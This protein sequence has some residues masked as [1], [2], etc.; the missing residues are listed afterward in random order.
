[1][2][3]KRPFNRR[4]FLHTT[5]KAGILLATP[6]PSVL[7]ASDFREHKEKASISVFSKHIQWLEYGPMAE[8]AADIGFTGIDLTV[9]PKGHVLPE[10]VKRDLPKA[11]KAIQKNGLEAVMMTTAISDPDDPA[12]E[13]ILKTAADLGIRYYRMGW[14]PYEKG[15]SLGENLSSI[16]NRLEKL[17]KLNEEAGIKGAYQNHAG[18]KFGAALWDLAQILDEM[19]TQWIGCQ[20]DIR[21]GKVEGANTWPITLQRIGKYINTL[22]I[23]DFV[24]EE[25]DK[26]FRV[27]NVPLGEGIVDFNSYLGMISEMKIQAPFSIHYEYDL[28]GAEHGQRENLK[29]SPE[30]IFAAMRKDLKFF[31]KL[32]EA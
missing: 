15:I 20:Y 25:T 21:H 19:D 32:L 3:K 30:E 29:L 31:K 24:W 22:D 13:A 17:A 6:L 18:D 26:G 14:I 27:K 5:A 11:V 2:S 10:N 4:E 12:T 1:M 9:R 28:G 8:A 7:Q 23:K 16:K